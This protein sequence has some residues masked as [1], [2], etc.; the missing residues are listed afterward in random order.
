MSSSDD[1]YITLPNTLSST[2]APEPRVDPVV[3]D[4]QSI[5]ERCHQVLEECRHGRKSKLHVA[6][7]LSR[8]I[9]ESHLEG[10]A[11]HRAVNTYL[12]SLDEESFGSAQPATDR[13]SRTIA[14]RAPVA[15]LLT[16]PG[17]PGAPA[18]IAPLVPEAENVPALPEA[19]RVPA[20]PEGPHFDGDFFPRQQEFEPELDRE[21]R[22]F[23]R[24]HSR[25]SS[26]QPEDPSKRR[27]IDESTLPWSSPQIANGPLQLD[28]I[29]AK[30]RDLLAFFARDIKATLASLLNSASLVAFPESEWLALL[31]GQAVNLD[32]VAGSSHSVSVGSRA[33]HNLADGIEL[34]L[35]VSEPARRIQSVEEWLYAWSETSKAL[36][37][38]FPHRAAEAEAYQQYIISH[39][40][41]TARRFHPRIL[42]L[43]KRI[44]LLVSGRR[45]LTLASHA[46][47]AET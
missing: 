38:V 40:K 5:L 20:L 13:R 42:L 12:A 8:I 2:S 25:V 22:N 29:A 45:D 16:G 36:V 32:K 19:E 34:H 44:R 15:S 6:V 1:F 27:C 39:F 33:T 26:H 4:P 18:V 43:D 24:P 28:A 35:G 7:E 47:F 46:A 17:Q 11:R 3:S 23:T 14:S 21:V 10:S 30:T 37:W 41:S 9:P 31:R